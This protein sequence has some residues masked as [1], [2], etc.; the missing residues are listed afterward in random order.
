M[1]TQEIPRLPDVASVAPQN[2]AP[3]RDLSVAV[4][5]M[6]VQKRLIVL[7]FLTGLADGKWGA[8]SKRALL[9]YKQ[10]ASLE[11]NNSWDAVTERSLFSPAAPH[12]VRTHPFIGGW[13]EERGQ[14]GAMGG[15]PLRITTDHAESDGGKCK[16]NSVQPERNDTWRID[17]ICTVIARVA[18]SATAQIRATLQLPPQPQP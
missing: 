1:P 15:A 16:F 13:T 3:T 4:D 8:Q 12:V 2:D 18:A 6:E 14:C 11:N 9:N 17:A 10:Q 7:G 5:A